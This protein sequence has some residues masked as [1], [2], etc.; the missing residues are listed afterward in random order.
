MAEVWRSVR[1]TIVATV[2][3]HATAAAAAAAAWAILWPLGIAAVGDL[4]KVLVHGGDGLQNPVHRLD[5][6]VVRRVWMLHA[7]PSTGL[8]LW[9]PVPSTF[10]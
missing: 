7:I 10:R 1:L 5:L 3:P 6:D 9:Y 4:I 8:H 2:V